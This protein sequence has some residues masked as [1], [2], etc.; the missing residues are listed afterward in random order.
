VDTF[1]EEAAQDR[2]NKCDKLLLSSLRA[3]VRLLQLKRR[4]HAAYSEVI[5]VQLMLS[6]PVSLGRVS[7]KMRGVVETTTTPHHDNRHTYNNSATHT[8]TK[9]DISSMRVVKEIEY[10]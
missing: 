2:V 10:G 7:V 1:A 9:P 5:V 6:S 3:Y 4:L 8:T